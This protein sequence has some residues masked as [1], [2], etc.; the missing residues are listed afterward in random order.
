MSDAPQT[1]ERLTGAEEVV[2]DLSVF[3]NSLDDPRIQQD[4]DRANQL[5]DDFVARYRGK[6]AELSAAEM[7]AV[8]ESYEA[9]MDIVG[10]LR[11][12]AGLN[13]TTY[14]TDAKWGAFTQKVEEFDSEIQQKLVFINLEW[15][16]LDDEKAEAILA[17]PALG[18]YRYHLEAARRYK[19]YQL[20]EAE[21]KLLIA[22][23]VTG[24][25]AWQRL[26][27]QIMAAQEYEFDGKRLPQPQ[28]LS[29]L[30]DGDR[31][32]RRKAADSLTVGLQE[33]KMELTYIFNTLAAD[34]G[35]EDRL[36]GYPSWVS[37]RN[38][39]NKASDATV[40]ALI[41]AVTSSYELVERHYRIKRALLGYDTLYDYDRYAPLNLKESEAFYTWEDA[42]Q[43]VLSAFERFSTTMAMVASKFFDENWIHAPV[44]S[45]K[46]GGAYANP[47]VPSA[48]PYVF[49]NYTGNS[50]SVM[51]LA[52]ELGHG[53]HMYLSAQD[54]VMASL[55]TPLTTAEMASVFAEML[56]FQDLMAKESDKEV[57]LGMLAEKIEDT[58]ATVFRQVSMNRF[59]HGMHTSRRTEGELSTERLSEIWMET[60]RAMF[61]DSVSLRDEYSIWWSYVPHFLHVPG[62]VYAYAFGE[63]LVLALYNLYQNEGAGFAPKYERLLAA[64]DSD[65]PDR[66]LAQVGIDLNDPDFWTEGIAAIKALVDQEEELARSLYPDR[67]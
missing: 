60:Q 3:Y 41:E 40:D 58:F 10:R 43:I 59:E 19:P 54:N 33:K 2:W 22:R 16:A 27:D 64:G 13:F 20:S 37:S 62:Y 46:R 63:L 35:M 66:L 1:E 31:E 55:Y 45:G 49:T 15:N 51:T 67:F 14:S 21:E 24:K 5:V 11:S 28:L 48:H 57:Q 34:K 50:S 17:D 38:L 4:M 36:R 44:M 25:N 9:I 12:Y 7:R 52:H 56:V 61:G 47:T 42:R 26:F 39:A 8:N 29:K 65:Y 23:D 18:G 32:A 53:I 30:K 6:I